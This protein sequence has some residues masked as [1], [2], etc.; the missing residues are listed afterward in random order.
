MA[1]HYPKENFYTAD[2]VNIFKAI[3]KWF[4]TKPHYTIVGSLKYERLANIIGEEAEKDYKIDR[5]NK[6]EWI[7]I[8]QR[9]V[10]DRLKGG[11]FQIHWDYAKKKLI[12]IYYVM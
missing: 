8:W 9:S 6:Y 10:P 12:E 3:E 1:Q 2:M 4:T 5:S 11:K 7:Y